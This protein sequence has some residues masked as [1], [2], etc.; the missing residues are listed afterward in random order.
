MAARPQSFIH[1]FISLWL[2]G[3]RPQTSVHTPPAEQWATAV[4]H[5]TYY[6]PF[7][8]TALWTRRSFSGLRLWPKWTLLLPVI[9]IY[10]LKTYLTIYG[11]Y[12]SKNIFKKTSTI[13]SSRGKFLIFLTLSSSDY[14]WNKHLH[15]VSIVLEQE[16]KQPLGC[17]HNTLKYNHQTQC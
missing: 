14:T 5:L 3:Y 7:I 16:E 1:D 10:R 15:M 4:R 8:T 11:K 13:A 12:F 17:I 2:R 6:A 9:F